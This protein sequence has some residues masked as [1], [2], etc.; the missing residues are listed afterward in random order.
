[1]AQEDQEDFDRPMDPS[2]DA[3]LTEFL[4]ATGLPPPPQAVDPSSPVK[5]TLGF[6]CESFPAISPAFLQARAEDI[7]SDQAKLGDFIA[8]IS[9]ADPSTL[10]TMAQYKKERREQAELEQVLAMKPSDFLV[11]FAPCPFSH[12]SDLARVVGQEYQDHVYYYIVPNFAG[13]VKGGL[14]KV[15]KVLRSNRNLLLPSWNELEQL[16]KAKKPKASVDAP[17]RGLNQPKP[18]KM[19]LDFMK[20]LIFIHLREKV[21]GL[22]MQLSDKRKIA[23]EA[24]RTTGGLFK[25]GECSSEENLPAEA[26][27]CSGGCQVCFSC[28]RRNSRLRVGQGQPEVFCSCGGEFSLETLQ[29]LLPASTYQILERKRAAHEMRKAG[30]KEVKCPACQTDVFPG[31]AEEMILDCQECG[32][33]SCLACSSAD[34]SPFPCMVSTTMVNVKPSRNI[35]D[36]PLQAKFRQFESHFLRQLSGHVRYRIQSM[37]IVDNP[38]MKEDFERKKAAFRERGIPAEP[39][40]AYHGTKKTVIASILQE[41]FDVSKA[42]RQ[43]HGRGNYFSEF[44]ETALTYSDDRKQLIL[45]EIL[46]GLSY[47][48]HEFTWPAYNSKLVQPSGPEG[49]SQMVIIEDHNQILP[50]AVIHL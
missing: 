40:Y 37:D 17:R 26:V 3:Y 24:A 31:S 13:K 4:P 39:I 22:S 48:G 14:T 30:L 15:K 20:E 28:V 19:D 25:C 18:R 11:E 10:P 36:D 16:P 29:S 45:C 27:M 38:R 21:R 41:N 35:S 6:L 34:H 1:M 42:V 50:V 47:S 44:P 49:Y 33:R 43:A 23:V 9:S 46:P 32:V 12:Y 2:H 8:Q 5:Q 7:G